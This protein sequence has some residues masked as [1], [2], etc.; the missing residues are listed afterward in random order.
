MTKRML[1]MI[2]MHLLHLFSSHKLNSCKCCHL[3]FYFFPLKAVLS[4]L[5]LKLCYTALN[6][7][8]S[9]WEISWK[10]VQISSYAWHFH[11]DK[12]Q[13]NIDVLVKFRLDVLSVNIDCE[14]LHFFSF[15]ALTSLTIIEKTKG[16]MFPEVSSL[17]T[18]RSFLSCDKNCHWL[19]RNEGIFVEDGVDE[20]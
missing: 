6:I 10:F 20:H 3:L 2:R 11:T 4:Y 1:E 7:G 12:I 9:E 13:L 19:L 16:K 8:A 15:T 5:T 14:P 17:I 18:W